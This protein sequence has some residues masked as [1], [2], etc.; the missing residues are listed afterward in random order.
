VAPARHG[1]GGGAGGGSAAGWEVDFGEG[2]GGYGGA[3]VADDGRAV[4]VAQGEVD[5]PDP[6]DGV[7]PHP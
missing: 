1:G 3:L 4:A 5:E 7:A 6:S 2:V